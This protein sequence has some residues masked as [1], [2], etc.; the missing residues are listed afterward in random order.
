MKQNTFWIDSSPNSYS[1]HVNNSD[2]VLLLPANSLRGKTH[3]KIPCHLRFFSPTTTATTKKKSQCKRL[4]KRQNKN[5]GDDD[6]SQCI[7]GGCIW[8]NDTT[9]N[10]K[11][12]HKSRQQQQWRKRKSSPRLTD[13]RYLK[14]FL[15]GTAK[16]NSKM[17]KKENRIKQ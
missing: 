3:S 12:I 15:S 11:A 9:N 7:E 4:L 13:M 8:Q 16:Q 5:R 6:F 14:A 1:S 2:Q 17:I 10:E